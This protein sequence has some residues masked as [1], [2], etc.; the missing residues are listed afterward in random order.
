MDLLYTPITFNNIAP[1]R[2]KGEYPLLVTL[3]HFFNNFVI[4]LKSFFTSGF[5]E[6]S[7]EVKLWG[8]KVCGQEQRFIRVFVDNVRHH[9]ALL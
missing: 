2:N 1:A 9:T 7:K 5:F 4:T 6:G 3:F 8:R